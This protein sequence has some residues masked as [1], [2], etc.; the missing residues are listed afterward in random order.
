VWCLLLIPNLVNSTLT[1]GSES[2]G[3][4]IGELKADTWQFCAISHNPDEKLFKLQTFIGNEGK[5]FMMDYPKFY[6]G[7]E[8]LELVLFE[9]V[10][11]GIGSVLISETVLS[12][13]EIAK[14]N[15][16]FPRGVCD[17]KNIEELSKMRID[18]RM[19]DW[20]AVNVTEKIVN[21]IFEGGLTGML[22]GNSGT[23]TIT[24]Y[25][26]QIHNILPFFYIVSLLETPQ[27]KKLLNKTLRLASIYLKELYRYID[28]SQGCVLRFR[29]ESKCFVRAFGY[30]LLHY[31]P[32]LPN[33]E[34]IK[35]IGNIMAISPNLQKQLLKMLVITMNYWVNIDLVV[36]QLFWEP[37]KTNLIVDEKNFTIFNTQLIIDVMEAINNSLQGSQCCAKHFDETVTHSLSER[38]ESMIHLV[39]FLIKNEPNN[40]S[41]NI[42]RLVHSL[43]KRPSSCLFLALLAILKDAMEKDVGGAFKVEGLIIIFKAAQGYPVEV[44]VACISLTAVCLNHKEKK[45]DMDKL[46]NPLIALIS[47]SLRR[48]SIKFG[49]V[50]DSPNRSKLKRHNSMTSSFSSRLL[51]I[52]NSGKMT[53]RGSQD[54]ISEAHE[55]KVNRK[56]TNSFSI[57]NNEQ[58]IESKGR[59]SIEF[60]EPEENSPSSRLRSATEDRY[61]LV[62]EVKYDEEP[63]KEIINRQSSDNLFEPSR[64][65]FSSIDLIKADSEELG[66]VYGNANTLY[67][68]IMLWLIGGR[69]EQ[70]LNL[71]PGKPIVVMEENPMIKNSEAFPILLPLIKGYSNETLIKRCLEDFLVLS[72]ANAF[73]RQYFINNE[74]FSE[75]LIRLET[76]WYHHDTLNKVYSGNILQNA[77]ELHICIL[78]EGLSSQNGA[79]QLA[80]YFLFWVCS[81]HPSSSVNKLG[82]RRNREQE[83]SI[84]ACLKYVWLGVI[85]QSKNLSQIALFTE[86]T[87]NMIISRYLV[88]A[89]GIRIKDQIKKKSNTLIKYRLSGLELIGGTLDSLLKFCSLDNEFLSILE[90]E[91]TCKENTLDINMQLL[92]ER[93]YKGV[94]LIS[95][96]RGYTNFAIILLS[97]GLTNADPNEAGELLARAKKIGQHIGLLIE[98]ASVKGHAKIIKKESKNLVLLLSIL[99]Y[100]YSSYKK[101][102][103]EYSKTLC[104]IL[105]FVFLAAEQLNGQMKEFIRKGLKADE[106]IAQLIFSEV[107]K[108]VNSKDNLFD[109]KQLYALKSTFLKEYER[110]S[111]TSFEILKVDFKKVRE[112]ILK[113]RKASVKV[114]SNKFNLKELKTLIPTILNRPSNA[115]IIVSK[116]D[117]EVRVIKNKIKIAE[118]TRK[119][120]KTQKYLKQWHGSWRDRKIFDRNIIV[121]L[122]LSKHTF[123]NGC[124]CLMKARTKKTKCLPPG[125]FPK[126]EIESLNEESTFQLLAEITLE[127]N[128]KFDFTDN[129]KNNHFVWGY[130]YSLIKDSDAAQILYNEMTNSIKKHLIEPL[131]CEIYTILY[132]IKGKILI[133]NKKVEKG[134]Y[135][136]F[137]INREKTFAEDQRL[138]FTFEYENNMKLVK[139][140]KVKDIKAMYKK[141][142]VDQK[143]ALEIVFST[144]KSVLYNF[145]SEGDR[146][147]FCAKLLNIKGTKIECFPKSGKGIPKDLMIDWVNWKI[148]NF[149][150]LMALNNLSGRS[151]N[152]ISQYPVFPWIIDDVN[153]TVLKL[154]NEN[155]YRNLEENVGMLGDEVRAEGFKDRFNLEDITGMGKFHFG[156]HYSNPGIVFQLMMRVSP[157][158]EAYIKFFTGLDHA[159]RMFHS[160]E[161][162]LNTAKKDPNDVRE[163]IPEFFSLS[164][165]LVNRERLCFGKRED[166]KEEVNDVILPLWAKANPYRFIEFQRKAL[167]SDCVSKS[168]NKWIDLIF[169]Y[170]QQGKEAEKACNVFPKL[171]YDAE[172]ILTKA[173]ESQRESFRMQAYHWG[174]TPMQL[175]VTRHKDRIS[176]EPNISYSLLD[177]KVHVKYT[178]KGSN[179]K[180]LQLELPAYRKVIKIFASEDLHKDPNF[181]IVTLGGTY[182]DYSI[183]INESEYSSLSQTKVL[184]PQLA[185]L[186][187]KSYKNL[188]YEN[189]VNMLSPL[190]NLHFPIVLVRKHGLP[191]LVQGGYINGNL[192]FTQ[193]AGTSKSTTFRAHKETVTCLEIDK[194]E[195]FAISGSAS[196]EVVIY[197]ILKEMNWVARRQMCNHEGAVTHIYLS[198]EM[199]LFCTSD[200]NSIVNLY[201]YA[202]AI[203]RKFIHPT[204][205]PITYVKLLLILGFTLTESFGMFGDVFKRDGDG[206]LVQFEW[207]IDV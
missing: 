24:K 121:P 45:F 47:G 18:K 168:I 51:E 40:L 158:I 14:F 13:E 200:N 184:S 157:F 146:D 54:I 138:M 191:Y 172:S 204:N 79:K 65:P 103:K 5:R 44:K 57:S 139:K 183:E 197:E 4:A 193:L 128:S 86:I 129:T 149:D 8:Y 72:K 68:T 199:Q 126:S 165:I 63:N 26:D 29:K 180:I 10:I 76:H 62:E 201:T 16:K 15:L 98:Y 84:W 153:S 85:R 161:E 112:A 106:N 104:D 136:K 50:L 160:I 28:R 95:K 36:L 39:K 174:Q 169:G 124:R 120:V 2:N 12:S 101:Q 6:K 33:E 9:D 96:E 35:H 196:G 20:T 173:S 207:R 134:Y 123:A 164:D 48:D 61:N 166:T 147:K 107:K 78:T 38:Y 176:K 125:E 97:A 154:S 52:N 175:L 163:L 102:I 19:T 88:K 90:F 32:A 75:W 116:D 55:Q 58:M 109:A 171:T 115:N 195:S 22:M 127:Q 198:A 41:Q 122:K 186:S 64:N 105:L 182:I 11:G 170:Q 17:I 49:R 67:A 1:L 202:G 178:G 42:N 143:S 141:N 77:L 113:K 3:I 135:I 80:S 142:V 145:S 167:E 144:G 87:I 100:H 132:A 111:Y 179:E 131:N 187:V 92:E 150:Y 53:E 119:W 203:L 185:R 140:W 59:E 130:D 23:Y 30:H 94:Q 56:R 148:S 66:I 190:I 71:K 137:V 177:K 83:D 181:A 25:L 159:D 74:E 89:K 151:F 110:V 82:I 31:D 205:A 73:N 70:A 93:R 194:E 188:Y 189:G 118:W 206:L 91:T 69:P 43:D 21:N 192:Q 37:I 46:K 117:N 108:C 60:M 162:S 34:T 7:S 81:M 152:N 27:A 114:Q 99:L 156:T 133:H 155:M